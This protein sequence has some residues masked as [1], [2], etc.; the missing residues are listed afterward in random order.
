MKWS[1]V[2]GG[3]KNGSSMSKM[4]QKV[5]VYRIWVLPCCLAP[6]NFY[7]NYGAN[8]YYHAYYQN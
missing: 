5:W 7:C 4:T 6:P 2:I 1:N 3:E 8:I